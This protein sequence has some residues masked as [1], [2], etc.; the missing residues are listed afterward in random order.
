M[1]ITAIDTLVVNAIHRN[2]IF[3]KVR[4]DQ[5]GLY[6]WGEATLEW[7]TK[8]VLGAIEDLSGFVIGEDPHRIEH[9]VQKMQ[10]VS[11]WPLGS[12]G[13][14]ALSGIEQALWDIK[15]KALGVPVWQL[16]G[17]R[18]RDRVRVYTHLLQARQDRHI[19]EGDIGAF[20]DA[21]QE[22]VEMGYSAVKLGLVPYNGYDAPLPALRHTEKLANAVRERVGDTIDIM[23]DFHGRP[24]SVQAAKAF[25]DVIAPIRPMFVEEPIQP[26]DPGALAQLASL[27]DCPLATGERLL[28]PQEYAELARLR[29]V[30][31]V[32]PDL[33]HCGGFSGGRRIAAI[34]EAASMGIMPHNPMGPV[35]GAVAL[36]F[37][38]AT[39]SFVIQEE[40]VGLAP[41]FADICATSPLDRVDGCWAIPEAPGLGIDIDE[42]E[43]AK[44]PYAPEVIPALQAILPDGRIANW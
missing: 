3:V 28:T 6:G 23:T 2:W 35:A 14:T 10:R 30:T 41:W 38:A 39:P 26:G 44:H 16:L 17:G 37:A 18:V 9:L 43:A 4:T 34:A 20:C 22:T 33:C 40:A 1:K 25:I 32:Q 21:V 29:A 31:F 24:D 36:Q 12:I 7:K 8:A 13:L 19:V 27:V 5:A 11:F 15:G 42:A